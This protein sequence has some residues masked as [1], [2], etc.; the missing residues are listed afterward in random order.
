[1]ILILQV[2]DCWTCLNC[3][4]YRIALVQGVKD[5]SFGLSEWTRTNFSSL[6]VML[7]VI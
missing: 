4:S 1:M 6:F 5:L 3:V 7:F 2:I